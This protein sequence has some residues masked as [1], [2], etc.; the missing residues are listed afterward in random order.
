VN[1]IIIVIIPWGRV[2]VK[3]A[4]I[5]QVSQSLCATVHIIIVGGVREAAYLAY[6][7]FCP[8]P[9]ITLALG[10]LWYPYSLVRN[11]IRNN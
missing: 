6:E 2:D 7:P 9:Y 11:D 4:S 3:E 5:P 10:A 8:V 1:V